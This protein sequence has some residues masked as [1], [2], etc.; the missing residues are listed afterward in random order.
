M[1]VGWASRDHFMVE[2]RSSYGGTDRWQ[3][4]NPRDGG[5]MSARAIFEA[6]AAGVTINITLKS[7][8]THDRCRDCLSLRRARFR[9]VIAVRRAAR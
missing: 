7:P 1:A 6:P 9:F 3:G 5:R 2:S 4:R 8:S